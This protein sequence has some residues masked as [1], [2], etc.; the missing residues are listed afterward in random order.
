MRTIR[1]TRIP[2]NLDARLTFGLESYKGAVS[3]LSENGAHIEMYSAGALSDITPE[4]ALE[5]EFQ[6]PSG[7]I[8]NLNCVVIWT[9]K[10][11]S[12]GFTDC[13]GLQI[14]NSPQKYEEEFLYCYSNFISSV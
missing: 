1:S 11:S 4:T 12:Q 3:N 8:L 2:V 7:R 9:G 10:A 6:F 5:L 14:L 13:M